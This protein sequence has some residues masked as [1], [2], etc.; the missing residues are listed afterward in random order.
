ME[1]GFYVTDIETKNR[2][3]LQVYPLPL[4]DGELNYI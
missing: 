1:T 4:D 3:N 2:K